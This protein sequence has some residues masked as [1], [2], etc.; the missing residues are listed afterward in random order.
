VYRAGSNGNVAPIVTLAGKNTSLF[1][2]AGIT[3]DGAGN[4]Y[5]TNDDYTGGDIAG[6][7]EVFPP[8]SNGNVTPTVI[9][10]GSCSNL[11]VPQGVAVDSAGNI[12]VADRGPGYGNTGAITEYAAGSNDCA[13]PEATISGTTTGLTQPTGMIVDSSGKLY[14][15]DSYTDSIAVF[16]AG[17]NGNVAPIETIADPNTGIDFPLGVALDTSGNI[18]IANGGSPDGGFDSITVYPVGSN[19][20]V[21]PTATIGAGAAADDETRLNCPD[22]IAVGPKGW[23]YVANEL[24]G[25][26][27]N[28]SVTAYSPGSNGNVAPPY[29]IAGDSTGDSTGLNDP[30]G[31]ALRGEY[32]YVLNGTGGPDNAGSVTVYWPSFTG[33]GNIVPLWTISGT[34]T[35]TNNTGFNYPSGLAMDSTGNIYVTNDGSVSGYADTVTV[36]KAGSYGNLAPMATISGS[37]TQLNMPSGIAIDSS[38]NIWVANDGSLGG[39]VDSITVY[40]PGS[41]GN[42]APAMVM[43]NGTV[44]NNAVV[45][46]PLTGL[47]MPNG[48]AIG[49]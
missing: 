44:T 49:G 38:G 39:G 36:Y 16:S 30:I 17:S 19:A 6:S 15:T 10:Y 32:I 34:S 24:G 33:W 23:M 4:I 12:Y 3:L 41:N 13:T 29:W 20:N 40:P 45:S 25:R 18:Y 22:A 48:L 9:I 11:N 37:L 1:T 47:N 5:V 8:G 35:T 42:V 28:G 43:S 26:D 31:V 21:A 27:G 7:I 14:I 2:P 46:G